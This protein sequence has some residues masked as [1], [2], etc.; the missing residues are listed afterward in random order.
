M[1]GCRP[2]VGGDPGG[3]WFA[4]LAR[5]SKVNCGWLLLPC[6]VQRCTNAAKRRMR[7]S[8]HPGTIASRR[9][10]RSPQLTGRKLRAS[11]SNTRLAS[12]DSDCDARV[13]HTGIGKHQPSFARYV[14]RG[15]FERPPSSIGE[16]YESHFPEKN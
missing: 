14:T 5:D 9:N 2:R 10:R 12:S 6:A 4:R 3:K 16:N 8:G 7:E 11:D 1:K 13:R 15:V